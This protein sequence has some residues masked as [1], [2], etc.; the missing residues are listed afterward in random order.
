VFKALEDLCKHLMASLVE[1]RTA[2]ARL[3]DIT[4][5][6]ERFYQISM[7]YYQMVQSIS[8]SD[9]FADPVRHISP[10]Q[11]SFPLPPAAFASFVSGLSSASQANQPTLV[12]PIADVS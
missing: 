2:I 7:G 1:G 8:N 10:L 9:P 3:K 6:L 4:E 5:H 11:A 12:H